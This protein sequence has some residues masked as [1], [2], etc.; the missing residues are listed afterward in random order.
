MTFLVAQTVKYLP[1][2]WETRVQFLGQEDLLEK[3]RET[4]SSILVRKIPWTEEPGR[5][6]SMGSQRARH[7]C[8]TSLSL[9]FY[10]HK[11]TTCSYQEALKAMQGMFLD[12]FIQGHKRTLQTFP[13]FLLISS[14]PLQGWGQWELKTWESYMILYMFQCPVQVRC[15]IQDAWGSCSG[16]I[17]RD[18]TGKEVGGGLRLGNTFTPVADS[19]WCM[20]KRIQYCK[21]KNKTKQN[22][23]I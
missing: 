6:Q 8:V 21:V 18:G 17:Q 2:I 20:A 4:H 9:H 10:V 1:I 3:E 11:H 16:M 22:L 15:R 23:G 7:D 13:L 14:G 12:P 5:L 19:C